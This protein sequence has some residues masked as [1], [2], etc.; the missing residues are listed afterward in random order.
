MPKCILI[1]DDSPSI[2]RA[3]RDFIER[4][5][6]YV[7]CGEAEDGLDAIEQAARLNPDLIILDLAMPRMNG[8]QAASEL[9]RIMGHVPLVLFTLYADAIAPADAA[10]AGLSAVVSKTDDLSILARSVENLLAA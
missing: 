4:Q 2:R 5:T 3:T 7:V 8:L 9:R 6:A 10:A 1:V